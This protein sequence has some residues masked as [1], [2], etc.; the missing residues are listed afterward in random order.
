MPWLHLAAFL[1]GLIYEITAVL[2]IHEQ[3]KL[4]VWRAVAWS[5]FAGSISVAGVW[6]AINDLHHAPAL[7]LGYGM[8]TYVGIRIKAR[9]R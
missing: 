4:H 9:L 8:G 7:V 6:L 2:W 1:C 3:S 5:V